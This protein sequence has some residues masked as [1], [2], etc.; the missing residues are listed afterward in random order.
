MKALSILLFL[1]LVSCE[2]QRTYDFECT[3]DYTFTAVDQTLC[4]SLIN[5]TV[6]GFILKDNTYDQMREFEQ[7]TEG[8]FV[9]SGILYHAKKYNC[10]CLPS[11]CPEY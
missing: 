8:Y 4:P 10:H 7:P 11:Y 5:S 2:S 9:I 1:I 6:T 3:C